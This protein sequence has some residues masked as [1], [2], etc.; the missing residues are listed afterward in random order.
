MKD[1]DIKDKLTEI[2]KV[3]DELTERINL[4]IEGKEDL[5]KLKIALDDAEIDIDIEIDEILKRDLIDDDLIESEDLINNMSIELEELKDLKEDTERKNIISLQKIE[6]Y[7]DVIE[8]FNNRLLDIQEKYDK[9]LYI[10]IQ[11]YG[12][13]ELVTKRKEE[14]KKKKDKENEEIYMKYN[15]YINEGYTYEAA[16]RL[17]RN[18]V[19]KSFRRIKLAIGGREND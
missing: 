3:L 6:D 17:I 11:K 9:D 18:E 16:V 5:E 19:G 1:E 2:N 12:R 7:L 15:K 10:E 13:E 4:F 14:R 8:D